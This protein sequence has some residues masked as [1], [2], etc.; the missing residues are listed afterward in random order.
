MPG[1]RP[2]AR[3]SAAS[4]SGESDRPLVRLS[5]LP[6]GRPDSARD[7][8]I[9]AARKARARRRLFE[10]SVIGHGGGTR[11]HMIAR[12]AAA[13]ASTV[14]PAGGLMVREPD[15]SM[16]ADVPLPRPAVT[17]AAD[18]EPRE[19]VGRL[20][21]VRTE[22]TA[23]AFGGGGVGDGG[24]GDGGGGGWG[25]SGG[26]KGGGGGE[27]GGGGGE[28]GGVGG[29]GFGSGGGG[30]DG[31]GGDGGGGGVGGGGEGGG[32]NC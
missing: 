23:G 8:S 15:C 31:S 28:G 25:E 9:R 22:V 27:G 19:S 10:P 11:E 21:T 7:V 18:M 32:I 26:G 24:G 4:S 29:G 6:M 17:S 16:E 3:R 2:N 30:G 13:I 1:G 12:N 14:V 5:L 20:T